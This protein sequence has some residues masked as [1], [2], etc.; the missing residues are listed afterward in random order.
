M[1]FGA[2]CTNCIALWDF[3]VVEM[4]TYLSPKN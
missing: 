3:A 4:K 2:A 1:A